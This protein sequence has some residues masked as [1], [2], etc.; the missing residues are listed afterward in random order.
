MMAKQ[1]AWLFVALITLIGTRWFYMDPAIVMKLDEHTLSTTPDQIIHELNVQQFD[2]KGRLIHS[3]ETPLMHH[4]PTNNTHWIKTPHILISQE[5]KPSWDI[6]SDEATAVNG[7]QKL[8]FN[9]NVII[10]Q[11]KDAH[12]SE[13]TLKS[14]S[15]TY[16]PKTK[17][18]TTKKDISFEQPGHQIQSTGMR[19]YLADNR[20]LLKHARG[21]YDPKL[22]G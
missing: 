11:E 22:N 14:E 16:Y 19:A 7:G 18:A 8:T 13:S 21:K 1:F 4:I 3:L 20:V 6:R 9:H 2:K 10:H 5:N 15:L 12:T 17:I